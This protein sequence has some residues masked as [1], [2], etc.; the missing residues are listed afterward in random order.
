MLYI[1]T[2]PHFAEKLCGAKL[3][4]IFQQTNNTETVVRR[5]ESALDK[6]EYLVVIRDTFC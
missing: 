4:T 5:N 3:H 6:R 2:L 1:K